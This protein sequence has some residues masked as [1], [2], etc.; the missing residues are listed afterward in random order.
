MPNPPFSNASEQ[1]VLAR[2][3]YR[4]IERHWRY[5]RYP[6]E[7]APE[8]IFD[9]ANALAPLF[10]GR[11]ELYVCAYGY[12]VSRGLQAK[13]VRTTMVEQAR[14]GASHRGV[15]LWSYKANRRPDPRV[16]NRGVS[17]G[18]SKGGRQ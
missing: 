8:Y 16:T 13:F 7:Q 17:T 4:L 14:M 18:V 5:L 11:L 3:A 6:P 15:C 12:H 9:L 2:V 1:E 10:F